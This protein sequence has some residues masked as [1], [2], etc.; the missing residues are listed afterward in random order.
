MSEHKIS[1]TDFNELLFTA[2]KNLQRVLS[3]MINL[4]LNSPRII[5]LL[6]SI[7]FWVIM[8]TWQAVAEPSL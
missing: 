3:L 5:V 6:P 7:D 1:I 2:T 4:L 8:N